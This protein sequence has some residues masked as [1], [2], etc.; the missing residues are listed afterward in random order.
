[1][2]KVARFF[3]QQNF[4]EK[5]MFDQAD[6]KAEQIVT[7]SPQQPEAPENILFPQKCQNKVGNKS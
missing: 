1:M 7:F 4:Y 3:F 5:N 2:K 6:I